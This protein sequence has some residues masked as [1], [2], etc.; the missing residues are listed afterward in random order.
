MRHRF[1]SSGEF[2]QS[3]WCPLEFAMLK[4]EMDQPGIGVVSVKHSSEIV[5]SDKNM[6][7]QVHAFPPVYRP[8]ALCRAV[9]PLPDAI[10]KDSWSQDDLKSDLCKPCEP[11][12]SED[13]ETHQS[14]LEDMSKNTSRSARPMVPAASGQLTLRFIRFKSL[15]RLNSVLLSRVVR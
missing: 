7:Q 14:R 8:N 15:V 12:A 2:S 3:A 1:R 4:Q 5:P 13:E 6:T 10:F 9:C 11:R